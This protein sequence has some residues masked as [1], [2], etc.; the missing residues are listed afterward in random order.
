MN[1]RELLLYH[2]LKNLHLLEKAPKRTVVRDLLGLQ[3]QF[4]RNPQLSLRLRASDYS[5][6][7]WGEGLVKIWS[8]RGTMHVIDESELGLYCSAAGNNGPFG[9]DF[10]GIPKEEAEK[11]A[12]FMQA[13]VLSGNDTRE[14]LKQACLRAGMEGALLEKV[15]HGWGGLI[16]EMCCRG[17]LCCATGT[18]KRYLVPPAPVFEDRDRARAALIE[19]YFDAFGPATVQDCSAF[20]LWKMAEL[21][22]LLEEILPRLHAEKI[23]GATYYHARALDAPGEIPPCVLVPGFDQLVLGYRDRTRCIDREHNAKLV[24]GAGIVFPALL[25]RG[26]LRAKWKIEGGR[27]VVT[28]FERLLKKDEA[29]IRREVKA[30]FG[31]EIAQIEYVE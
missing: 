2:S 4:S 28:P 30:K 5:P 22:P 10:W 26:R 31:K 14:G 15:F 29:A 3:A 6:E 27:M 25:L 21:R 24:N 9:Q 20:F 18:Q 23:D 8:H 16:K 12:P 19:R 13:Q 1:E 11:W 17:M 7:T